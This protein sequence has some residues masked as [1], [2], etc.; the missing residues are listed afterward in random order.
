M[1]PLMR[2]G[3]AIVVADSGMLFDSV[4]ITFGVLLT[5]KVQAVEVPCLPTIRTSRNP[6]GAS[7]AID[8]SA[9]NPALALA[10]DVR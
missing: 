5:S 6:M 3:N 2:I 1:T 9:V 4:S 8:N 10:A 7:G